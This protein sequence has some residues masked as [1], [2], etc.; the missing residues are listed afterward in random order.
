VSGRLGLPIAR[1]AVVPAV[2]VLVAV[3]ALVVT[4]AGGGKP[5]SAED[6][7][8]RIAAGLRCP[9]CADLSA[10]DSPAPIARQMRRQIL[11]Q[12]E[13]GVPEGQ[14][15]QRY[16]DAYGPSV[17]LTPRDEGWGRVAHVLP[18]AVPAAAVLCGIVV[19]VRGRR[20]ARRTPETPLDVPTAVPAVAQ[21]ASP[22]RRRLRTVAATVAVAAGVAV[23]AGTQLAGA[24]DQRPDASPPGQ[25]EAADPG[26][27]GRGSAADQPAGRRDSAAALSDVRRDVRAAVARVRRSPSAPSAHLALAS[28]YAEAGRNRLATIEYLATT[29]LQPDNAEANTALALTAFT[30]GDAR[31]AKS[32]VDKALRADPGYPEALYTRGLVEAMGLRRPAAARRDFRAYLHAAPFGSHRTSVETLLALLEGGH[33]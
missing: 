8:D 21:P 19:V 33:R 31:T 20:R 26:S 17:L 2:A 6:R 27:S 1:A 18:V 12:V 4:A 15:R 7:A 13:R 9:V 24:I 30:S 14:I 29:S 10:A 5:T 11:R 23:L 16:V 22:R 25:A 32:L 28:A 3:V